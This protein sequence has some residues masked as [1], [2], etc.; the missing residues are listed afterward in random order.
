MKGLFWYNVRKQRNVKA[1]DEEGKAITKV[2]EEDYP[3]C[4]SLSSV[5]RAVWMDEKT[6]AVLL[7]DGHE[8]AE[9]VQRPVVDKKTG[10]IVG[11]ELKR[12]RNWVYSQI[13][14]TGDDIKRFREITDFSVTTKKEDKEF[15][16]A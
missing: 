5:I 2:V 7:N 14:L 16:V 10:K 13:N 15:E 9:E 6:L 8:Q 11:Q 3:E 4:F 1:T 12:E